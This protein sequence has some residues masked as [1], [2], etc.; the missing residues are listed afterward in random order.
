MGACLHQLHRT[1]MRI[2]GVTSFIRYRTCTVIRHNIT[3]N[4]FIVTAYI[5]EDADRVCTN[6]G[7]TSKSLFFIP[8]N[9][10]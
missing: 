4:F 7:Y 2:A 1:R 6:K 8:H 5:L 3:A 10:I 9:G